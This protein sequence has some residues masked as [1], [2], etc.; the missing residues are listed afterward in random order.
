MVHTVLAADSV[1][2]GALRGAII[3]GAIGAVVGLLGFL[4]KKK[5]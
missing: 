3:G 2:S 5:K 4:F 1:M